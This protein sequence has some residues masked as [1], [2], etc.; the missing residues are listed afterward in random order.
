MTSWRSTSVTGG[1][2]SAL[3][4][5]ITKLTASSLCRCNL[6]NTKGSYSSTFHVVLLT[7]CWF[8]LFQKVDS[9][10]KRFQTS[11][12]KGHILHCWT[13]SWT[14]SLA[15][16]QVTYY[17]YETQ[18]E[19]MWKLS[20]RRISNTLSSQLTVMTPW[21]HTTTWATQLP[22]D[23]LQLREKHHRCTQQLLTT[24]IS[25]HNRTLEE[26]LIS[27]CNTLQTFYEDINIFNLQHVVEEK[28]AC[29][30]NC[31]GHF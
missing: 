9:L 3:T 1:R 2:F 29:S 16:K 11:G 25:I 24:C 28:P 21:R 23:G 13:N 10:K 31:S 5:F 8:L 22:P 14:F 17:I 4:S 12:V 7:S 30:E 19:N 27:V 6:N 26:S 15:A 18:E 20:T